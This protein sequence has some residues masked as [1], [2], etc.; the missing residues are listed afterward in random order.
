MIT[1]KFV[2]T[3]TVQGVG[4]RFAVEKKVQEIGATVW[5]RNEPDGSV[6]MV[7]SGEERVLRLIRTWVK[8][9]SPGKLDSL[10]IFDYP[11]EKFT[12]FS[13]QY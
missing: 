3:G 12:S 9:S 2:L 4:L 1:Q 13:I 7:V 11:Y 6:H 8:E 10:D 5:V